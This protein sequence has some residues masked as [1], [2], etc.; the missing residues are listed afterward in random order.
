MSENESTPWQQAEAW[1]GK[2]QRCGEESVWHT[3]SWFNTELICDPCDKAEWVHPD[4]AF[5]KQVD[6]LYLTK[7]REYNYPG[8]GWPGVD[9]RLSEE[10]KTA[11]QEE[12][13]F[14]WGEEE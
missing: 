10:L 3:M 2:C 9:G 11:L 6:F 4:F 8:P 14:E 12:L 5:V 13:E 7:K 1:E